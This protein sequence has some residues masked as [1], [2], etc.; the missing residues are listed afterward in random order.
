MHLHAAKHLH[1]TVLNLPQ[2]GTRKAADPQTRRSRADL[3]IAKMTSQPQS[4]VHG[5]TGVAISSDGSWN[6]LT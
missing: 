2:D 3:E 6:N 4:M 1:P 5:I